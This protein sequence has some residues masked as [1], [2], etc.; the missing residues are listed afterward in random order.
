MQLGKSGFWGGFDGWAG[1]VAEHVYLLR[2]TFAF[3]LALVFLLLRPSV[4]IKQ[5]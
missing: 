1:L 4:E 5:R 2:V 3:W